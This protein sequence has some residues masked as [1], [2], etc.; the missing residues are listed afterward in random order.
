M[1]PLQTILNEQIKRFGPL[2]L[3]EYM[4]LCLLHPA[5]GYYTTK[6]PLGAAGDF[7]TAPEISQMFGEMLGLCLIETWRLQGRP[8]PF[9]L[10]ELGP[11]RG[12]LMAD[13]LRVGAR[14]PGFLEAAEIWLI[15]ASPSLQAVQATTLKT[16]KINWG[17]QVT[18]LPDLPLFLVANEFFDALPVR[19]FQRAKAGWRE[20]M[21]G[22]ENG[23]LAFGLAAP[24]PIDALEDQ[25]DIALGHVLETNSAASA[26]M[27]E[28]ANRI[29][30]N[31]GAA[32][33]VDYGDWQQSGS[34][35]QAVRNHQKVD[36]LTRPG[37]TDLSAHVDFAAL[38]R[39]AKGVTHTGLTPQGLLLERLGITA[40][41]QAL[42]TK[43]D[44]AALENHIT[45]HRRL[46]HPDEMGSLFKAIG[47]HPDGTPPPP[48][49]EPAKGQT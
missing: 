32:L 46:T 18:D 36:P 21:V 3:A 22:L 8:A 12:T 11:G 48:G 42:A 34:S 16:Y 31:G 26:I 14:V 45:A 40:R 23:S 33:I 9:V 7:T 29:G 30:Q 17:A 1:T 43:L 4:S 41:A 47:F 13:I 39:S 25:A 24:I 15:E 38:A 44:G 19:Q 37:E 27:A 6:R 28:I 10:A 49:F 2:S 35:F 20:R 5:H